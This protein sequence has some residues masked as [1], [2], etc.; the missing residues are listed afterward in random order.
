[1]GLYAIEAALL[2]TFM[3]SACT[4]GM[5]LEHP[6]SPVRRAIHDG[7][8]RR[9]I[10]GAAM[11]LTAIALIYSRCGRRS[12]ALMNPAMTVSF[13]RLGR[14]KPVDA[15]FYVLA[16]FVG[17]VLGVMLVRI[18]ASSWVAHPSVNHV[19]T[20]PSAYGVAAAWM[21]EFGIA[22]LMITMVLVINRRPNLVQR[23]GFFAGGLVMLYITFEAP[24]SGMS[25]NPAR[26]FGSAFNARVFTAL[27]I[28]FTAPVLGML[29]GLEVQRLITRTPHAMCGKL[30][31]SRVVPCFFKCNCLD[32]ARIHRD[33]GVERYAKPRT[34]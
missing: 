28:Y 23:T 15:L 18:V 7:F 8:V 24:I 25:L 1:L 2:G 14:I 30:S 20:Q 21:A 6:D 34:V 9:V 13:L 16:Q 33:H 17:A 26:T 19:V 27:W 29:A 12:G 11:G 5:L 10:M 3:I 31:H 32:A 4:F 22:F